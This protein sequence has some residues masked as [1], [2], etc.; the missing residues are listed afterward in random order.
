MES[1]V[2]KAKDLEQILGISG[3]KV[4]ELMASEGFP[5]IRIGRRIVVPKASF[6]EWLMKSAAEKA[7]ISLGR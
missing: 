5:S 3:P 2:F 1:K 6:E 4:Y 7:E